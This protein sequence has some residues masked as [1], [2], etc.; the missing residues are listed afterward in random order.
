MAAQ[1]SGGAYE[2]STRM[3]ALVGWGATTNFSDNWVWDQ[4][5]ETYVNDEEMA[6]TLRKNNPQAFSNVLRRMIEAHGRGMWDASPELLAQL[7]G[8]YG[9][10]DDELEGVGSGGGKK[11]K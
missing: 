10:M 9:E 3:T 6:A 11:K 5:A 1:G 8:L 4:A 2:I 7:R